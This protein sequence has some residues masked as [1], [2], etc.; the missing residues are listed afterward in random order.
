MTPIE[1]RRP[2]GDRRAV[3]RGGRRSY[4]RPGRFPHLLVA[5]SYDGARIPCARYLDHFGFQ[6]DQVAN[7]RDAISLIKVSLPH[8]ILAE[9]S[10]P[11]VSVVGLCEWLDREP[12]ARPVPVIVMISDFEPDRRDQLSQRAAAVLIKP[13]P[14]SAMLQEVRRVLRTSPPLAS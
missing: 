7:G 10:L 1:R 8:L 14:L 9:F 12:R 5:D 4:D 13:F 3:P 11:S 6:V 2:Q